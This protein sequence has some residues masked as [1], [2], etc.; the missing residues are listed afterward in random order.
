MKV[1]RENNLLKKERDKSKQKKGLNSLNKALKREEKSSRLTSINSDI[2]KLYKKYSE[3][4]KKRLI[5]EKSQQMLIN[6]LKYLRN[7]VKRSVSR[8]GKSPKKLGAINER[9]K[10]IFVKVNSKYKKNDIIKESEKQSISEI[11][12]IESISKASFNGNESEIIRS[13]YKSI[14]SKKLSN[15]LNNKNSTKSNSNL[16]EEKANNQ[17]QNN[18]ELKIINNEINN[19]EDFLRKYKYN[20]GNKNSNNNIYIIINNPN[21]N[22]S[23]EK[24]L[25]NNFENNNKYDYDNLS[26]KDNTINNKNEKY[27]IK[28]NH[29]QSNNFVDL[30]KKG[31]NIILMNA[32]GKKLQDIINSINNL[33]NDEED[34]NSEDAQNIKKF[35][36][37]EEYNIKNEKNNLKKE[38][39]N[40]NEVIKEKEIEN[41]NEGDNDKKEIKKKEEEDGFIRPSFL[42][43]Y[44]N[45]ENSVIN[46][47]LDL[48]SYGET[49]RIDNST[50][51]KMS[52]TNKKENNKNKILLEKENVNED[53]DNIINSAIINCVIN[54]NENKKLNN[55]FDKNNKIE[56]LTTYKTN[57][58]IS[59]DNL[60]FYKLYNSANNTNS[61]NKNILIPK[62]ENKENIFINNGRIITS[63]GILKKQ[64]K[65]TYNSNFTKLDKKEINY[66]FSH[67]NFS[68]NNIKWKLNLDKLRKNNFKK[69]S[70]CTSIEKKRKALGL[71]FK[72]NYER[73]LS[74]QTEKTEKNRRILA[75]IKNSKIYNNLYDENKLIKVRKNSGIKKEK[76][77]KFMKKNFD[78]VNNI[79]QLVKN[80][81]TSNFNYN[82]KNL[83]SD[84]RN[85]KIKND[86]NFFK[87]NEYSTNRT[88][89]TTESKF[90]SLVHK[91]INGN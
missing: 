8:K 19:I 5:K 14:N 28:H 43:L 54:Q 79:H 46:P 36:I 85:K 16:N 83:E 90:Y 39:E 84:L 20:I 51:K 18:N 23:N 7:E 53:K 68:N 70:Y 34:K 40:K 38:D 25:K 24:L 27:E 9:N 11:F 72:H 3:V 50:E 86:N 26:V 15:D 75:R 47:K 44:N 1:N 88:N 10:K 91:A 56:D 57:N 33:N 59:V 37:K 2:E 74:I 29:C 49:N 45:E 82:K 80:R 77:F 4:K 67:K 52:S 62:E 13:S 30:G 81:T 31:E 78:N 60:E 6:R 55:D 42:N 12:D 35:E 48:N 71:E 76:R 21:N 87:S 66:S 32:D 63:N 61:K 41:N 69:D 64:K 17:K 65:L 58:T 73:D 22:F 89:R